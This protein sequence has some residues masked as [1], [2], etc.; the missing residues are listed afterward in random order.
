MPRWL[1]DGA[2]R[3]PTISPTEY[4]R[5]NVHA[6]ARAHRRTC[7]P[8]HRRDLRPVCSVQRMCSSSGHSDTPVCTPT[9]TCCAAGRASP[10]VQRTSRRRPADVRPRGARAMTTTAP[11]SRRPLPVA[12]PYRIKAVEPL[13]HRPPARSARARSPRP[14][15]TRSFC[16]AGRLHRPAHRQRHERHERPAVGGDDDRRRGVR[17]VS[18]ASTA[19][20]RRSGRLRLPARRPDAPGP[21]RRAPDLQDPHQGRA[22]TCPATCTSP[23]RGAHQELA[24]GTFVDVVIDEA[25]DA[26]GRAPVQ[27]QRR[28]RQAGRRSS[29]RSAPPTSPTSTSRSP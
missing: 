1:P 27:G 16:A 28:P 10:I 2:T 26:D 3:R 24:G 7:T 9:V 4:L 29:S 19:S 21:R 15:T 14:A 5:T 17:R 20:R 6:P 22:S 11:R 23:R 18:A 8:V 13:A 25:H 12:E